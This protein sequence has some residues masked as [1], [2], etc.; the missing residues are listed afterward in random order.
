MYSLS[1]F[2]VIENI[3]MLCLFF[4]LRNAYMRFLWCQHSKATRYSPKNPTGQQMKKNERKNTNKKEAQEKSAKKKRNENY[5]SAAVNGK[6]YEKY[7]NARKMK[8]DKGIHDLA[9]IEM[10]LYTYEHITHSSLY[11]SIELQAFCVHHFLSIFR[12]RRMQSH[13]KSNLYGSHCAV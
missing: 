11:A 12:S 3:S 6:N 9:E 4:S 10:N 5:V 1:F 7:K 2:W 13:D 8:E